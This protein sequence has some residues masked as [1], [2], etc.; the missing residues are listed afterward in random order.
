MDGHRTEQ[1]GHIDLA[2]RSPQRTC[3]Q[4]LPQAQSSVRD[5]HSV[6]VRGK[7]LLCSK[8]HCGSFAPL[9]DGSSLC[10]VV[11]PPP[12]RQQ[13]PLRC[14]PPMTHF[15]AARPGTSLSSH[16]R[17]G[18]KARSEQRDP[19]VTAGE[20]R[21][22]LFWPCGGAVA[23]GRWPWPDFREKPPDFRERPFDFREQAQRAVRR[24]AGW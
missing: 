13:V 2:L 9:G 10:L 5:D 24:R 4:I 7:G 22:A 23:E 1:A 11:P 6:V 8:P 17:K 21:F 14:V 20:T 19:D 15:M 3:S 18:G 16:N 12:L